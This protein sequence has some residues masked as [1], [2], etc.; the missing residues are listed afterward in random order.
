MS[1]ESTLEPWAKYVHHGQ[2]SILQSPHHTHLPPTCLP[3]LQKI[4]LSSSPR[5]APT[6]VSLSLCEARSVSLESTLVT[7]HRLLWQDRLK[8]LFQPGT[9]LKIQALCIAVSRHSDV[10][11]FDGPGLNSRSCTDTRHCTAEVSKLC[12]LSLGEKHSSTTVHKERRLASEKHK[13]ERFAH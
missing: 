6:L 9:N 2:S 4:V 10:H 13:L 11:A 5:P 7:G 3:L 1:L 12:T 8:A